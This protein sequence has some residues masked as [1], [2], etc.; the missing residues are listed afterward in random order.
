M[1]NRRG[2]LKSGL[3]AGISASLSRVTF[4]P[5]SAAALDG[6][7][8]REMLKADMIWSSESVPVPLKENGPASRIAS[9]FDEYQ[10]VQTPDLHAVFAREFSLDTV[11]SRASIRLFSYTRYR[12][13]IN[14]VYCGRG[15]R[16][17]PESAPGVR[18]AR[19]HRN[20]KDRQE[21]HCGSD[22]SRC[23]NWPDHEPRSRL[24]GGSATWD[25]TNG[26]EHRY[27][28]ELAIA[29]RSFLRPAG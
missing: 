17:V 29:S 21:H 25:W 28:P 9:S 22:P 12:L 27:R 10:P 15:P 23:S 8:S 18:Y 20:A 14:G 16:P 24:C 3:A 5:D 2:F 13:Y 7:Q 4:L 19:D 6:S 26:E 1:L 11:P